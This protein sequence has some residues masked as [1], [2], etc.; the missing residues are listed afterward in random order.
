MIFRNARGIRRPPG[1]EENDPVYIIHYRFAEF[2]HDLGIFLYQVRPLLK[3]RAGAIEGG[4]LPKSRTYVIPSG[5]VRI[6]IFHR[7]N[8][9]IADVISSYWER[10]IF[11]AHI[12]TMVSL[13]EAVLQESIAARIKANID[14]LSVIADAKAGVPLEVITSSL[15]RDEIIEKFVAQR[16]EEM[17]L[18]GRLSTSRRRS[19]CSKYRYLNSYSKR[20][21][22]SKRPET[23]L[24]TIR[25]K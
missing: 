8:Q 11:E 23:S 7:S 16:C 9:E 17:M 18:K 5:E 3:E 4:A 6:S 14:K 15:D 25:G 22:K 19:K 12:V 21:W 10:G 2:L 1:P 13:F 20:S 24:F